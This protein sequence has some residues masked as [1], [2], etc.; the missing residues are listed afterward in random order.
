MNNGTI[1]IFLNTKDIQEKT[2]KAT[3]MLSHI[4]K[5]KNVV[6]LCGKIK[7]SAIP[8]HKC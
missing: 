3:E 7:N 1:T 6:I 8:I 2:K 4:E 5:A